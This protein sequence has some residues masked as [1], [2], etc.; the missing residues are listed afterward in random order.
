MAGRGKG[1]GRGRGRGKVASQPSV[2]PQSSH[3][4]IEPTPRSPPRTRT[5]TRPSPI[6]LPHSQTVPTTSLSSHSQ[7]EPAHIPSPH[8]QI[9][10]SSELASFRLLDIPWGEE[11]E[12]GRVW[13]KP[14]AGNK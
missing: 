1:R 12:D 10:A 13:I 6:N 2:P 7:T 14:A 9:G 5:S 4:P 8:L 3:S 11:D